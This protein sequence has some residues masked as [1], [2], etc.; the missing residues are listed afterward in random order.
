M[1]PQTLERFTSF[2]GRMA[3]I[4]G[5]SPDIA[6]TRKF[7]VAPSVQQTLVT[8]MQ[9]TIEFLSEINIIPVDE[10]SGQKLGLGIGGTI[11]G[12][13]N[14]AGGTRRAGIDPTAMDGSD[15]FC[16][17]TNFDTALRYDKL[18][19]WAKFPDFET[20]IRDA[21]V[22]RQALDRLTIGFNGTSAADQTDR[23]ANPLLQDVNK[24]WLQKMRE[25]SPKRVLSAVEGGKV[26]GKVSYGPNGDFTGIDAMVWRAKQVLL[27]AWARQAPGLVVLVGDDLIVDKYGPIMDAAEGSLDTLA[28]AAVMA[29][30]QL[31]GLPTVRVPYFPANAFLITTLN[32]LS[33]YY[34]DGKSRRLIK[35]EPELDQVTDYQSSNE[36][37]VVEDYSF[38]ALVENI[39]QAA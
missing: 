34:Q 19:M 8:R 3:E 25:D 5:V 24:G 14:T 2:V 6:A 4:N 29:D 9:E 16:K 33:I 1:K 23:E 32:N 26:A 37:Y 30:R 38:S 12:R 17:Q 36:A 20:R 18:D 28:K 11:A 35:D 10:Q 13:T 15:Y 21:I 31:G 22:T 39:A 27:P 7:T